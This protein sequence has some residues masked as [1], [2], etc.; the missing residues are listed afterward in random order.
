M[1]EQKLHKSL[2]D[3]DVSEGKVDQLLVELEGYKAYSSTI[4][5]RC[6]QL[7]TAYNAVE[8]EKSELDARYISLKSENLGL[9]DQNNA[10]S[11]EV[12]TLKR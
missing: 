8:K 12:E 10:L 1:L 11:L 7:I 3:Q 5:E 6:D 2:Q 4:Q 9:V